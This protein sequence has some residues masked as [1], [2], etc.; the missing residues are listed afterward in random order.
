MIW[1][2]GTIEANSRMDINNY[3]TTL[4]NGIVQ[5]KEHNYDV[6]LLESQYYPGVGENE[7]YKKYLEGMARIGEK[8]GV[9]VI[10]R[11]EFMQQLVKE[12]K[13]KWSELLYT[14]NFRPSAL[15]YELTANI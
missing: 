1:Q 8:M 2:A 11:Y 13:Y 14:D 15:M 5:L 6:M 9:H 10:H 3:L 12:N 4:E 7:L